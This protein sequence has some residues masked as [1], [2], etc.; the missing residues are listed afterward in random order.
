MDH[1]EQKELKKK[2]ERKEGHRQ[3][4]AGE[5]VREQKE[6]KGTRVIR[7]LWLGVIGIV[8]ATLALLRWMAIL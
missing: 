1:R 7:P 6:S 4:M 8:L 2:H 5:K 3:E